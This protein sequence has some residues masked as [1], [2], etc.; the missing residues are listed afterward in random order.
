MKVKFRDYLKLLTETGERID[1]KQVERVVKIL[2]G[3]KGKKNKI[4]IAG[5]G[6]SAATAAHLACDLSKTV[7]P[8]KFRAINLTDNVPAVTAIG[9]DEDYKEIFSR[10]LEN[11]GEKEDILLVISASGNSPNILEVLKTAKK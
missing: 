8:G 6:G 11:L 1:V 7:G 10:Q 2:A 5:N 4:F 9:N 3:I